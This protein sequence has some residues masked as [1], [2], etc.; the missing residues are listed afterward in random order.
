MFLAEIHYITIDAA[1]PYTNARILFALP[2]QQA[3]L[4][5]EGEQAGPEHPTV[6]VPEPEVPEP[7]AN[8]AIQKKYDRHGFPFNTEPRRR[9]RGPRRSDPVYKT[10]SMIEVVNQEYQEHF[11]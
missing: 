6:P 5:A 10:E 7:Q 2:T 1:T 8:P 4:I 9:N 11:R 3:E